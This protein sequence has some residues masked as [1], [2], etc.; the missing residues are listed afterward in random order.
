MSEGTWWHPVADAATVFDAPLAVTLLGQDLVLWRDA[1]GALHAF[2]DR[3]PHRGTRLSLGRVCEGRLE[4]AYHGWRFAGDGACV[5][6]PALPAFEPPPSHRATAYSVALGYGLVWV[7]LAAQGR[8]APPNF[9]GETDHRLRKLLVGPYDV[10]T[11][12][13]RIVENFLDLAHFGFIHPGVLGDAAHTEVP[14]YEVNVDPDGVHATGCMAW[15]PQSHRRASAGEWIAYDYAVPAPYTAVLSK[16]PALQGGAR[17]AIALL[18]CPVEPER[19][20]VWFRMA[21]PDTESSDA[22]LREFQHRIFMQDQPVLESQRPKCL[23]LAGGE[24]HCAADRSS[25]AYRRWLREL[26]IG[27]GV[28]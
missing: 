8:P 17:E 7:R 22:E 18:I 21:T 9:D 14:A 16:A 13:P 25:S 19:S 6:I 2:A 4:C 1:A 11:S 28:T 23:P 10:A 12:A 15:Q 24:V 27:F 3:C 20:R 26:N 5:R